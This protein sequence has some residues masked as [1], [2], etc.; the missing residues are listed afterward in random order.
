MATHKRS[1]IGRCSP[2][3]KR[4]QELRRDGPHRCAQLPF[5]YQCRIDISSES[6]YLCACV[7]TSRPSRE[8][9]CFPT[10]MLVCDTSTEEHE[11]LPAQLK[12]QTRTHA[13]RRGPHYRR[14]FS[15]GRTH[16]PYNTHLI[17]H[18]RCSSGSSAQQKSHSCTQR[19]SD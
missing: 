14:G 3:H 6:T 2:S 9:A 7:L 8:F 18:R 16:Q 13:S 1:M 17:V 19:W 11:S 12:Q 4:A 5:P 15:A 10:Q